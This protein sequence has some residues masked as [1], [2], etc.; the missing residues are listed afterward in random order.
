MKIESYQYIFKLKNSDKLN[1]KFIIG[2]SEDHEAFMKLILQD[3]NVESCLREYNHEID[4]D[5]F[6][7]SFT[8][9]SSLRAT[10]EECEEVRECVEEK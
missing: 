4:F 6:G 7:V 5:K 8:V 1:V 9:K 2:P 3:D 10:K